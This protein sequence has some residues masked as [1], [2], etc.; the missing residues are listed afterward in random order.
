MPLFAST[1]EDNLQEQSGT[2]EIVS[3]QLDAK[4]TQKGICYFPMP[5]KADFRLDLARF[6][7]MEFPDGLRILFNP[8]QT[9]TTDGQNVILHFW[10]ELRVI[11]IAYNAS[12]DEILTRVLEIAPYL[13]GHLN[14]NT[15][16]GVRLQSASSPA[17]APIPGRQVSVSGKPQLVETLM[18]I[19]G[20]SYTQ[21]VE[22]SFPYADIQISSHA[23]WIESGREKP[24]LV[25]FG[26]FYGDAIQALE[27]TG[28]IVI[29][30]LDSDSMYQAIPRLLTAI[31]VNYSMN[32]EIQ[33]SAQPLFGIPG[34]WIPRE[35][36]PSLY[37]T[38]AV[39]NYQMIRAIQEKGIILIIEKKNTR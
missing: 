32:S 21:N 30:I 38:D 6:P 1:P 10:P 35:A 8:G 36:L 9:L 7:I 25:D 4:L 13:S 18:R 15:Q 27:K 29:Q 37:L 14:Q 22:M 28:F 20:V 12:S 34:I 3:V 33:P 31:G 11:D 23:N 19:L 2:F 26:S 39:P 24:V 16:A 17:A 5:G